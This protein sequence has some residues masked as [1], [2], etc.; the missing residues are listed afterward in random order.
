PIMFAVPDFDMKRPL[1]FVLATALT[2]ASAFGQAL[3]E[4]REWT[5]ADGKKITAELL[6]FDSG[7]A[8]DGA[9]LRQSN[10]AVHKLPLARFSRN[11]QAMI[12]WKRV[13]SQ[14][15]VEMGRDDDQ[16]FFYPKKIGSKD[17]WKGRTWAYVGSNAEKTWLRFSSYGKAD[18]F[19]RGKAIIFQ[20]SEDQIRV[21]YAEDD[22]DIDRRRNSYEGVDFSIT[23]H[24]NALFRMLDGQKDF[25]IFLEISSTNMV[26]FQLTA[27][28]KAEL[29]NIVSIHAAA[30]LLSD[31]Q[32][33]W[34]HVL[35]M[36]PDEFR[37]AAADPL[38]NWR[39]FA[40]DPIIPIRPWTDT[41]GDIIEAEVIGF[42]RSN[43]IMRNINGGLSAIR[44]SNFEAPDLEILALKRL[45]NS[46]LT[47][48][49]PIDDSIDYYWPRGW[50]DDNRFGREAFLFGIDKATRQPVLVLQNEFE[51]VSPDLNP[52]SVKLMSENLPNGLMFALDE[53]SKIRHKDGVRFWVKLNR[54]EIDA[55]LYRTKDATGIQYELEPK[56]VDPEAPPETTPPEPDAFSDG[57]FNVAIEAIEIFRM[58]DQWL[59]ISETKVI[60]IPEEPAAANVE[61]GR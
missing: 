38:K 48:W 39:D 46:L 24:A 30:A 55:L 40:G 44:T 25:N 60:E 3:T 41:L 32:T 57:E 14:L 36:D 19:S 28:E 45:E 16:G 26:P 6:V 7:D 11:D 4:E 34:A 35:G 43:V 12:L 1:S 54:E 51:Q 23:D 13:E 56:E 10:G 5:S 42:E 53:V 47:S 9:R 31:D 37:A 27:E 52:E 61:V 58:F 2:A 33:W 20:D 49:H 15:R 22:L 8:R 50:S 18:T 29:T 17:N 59:A 21:E